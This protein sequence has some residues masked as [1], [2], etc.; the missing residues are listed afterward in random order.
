M[1]GRRP[2]RGVA[3][4]DLG[5]G[6]G[7]AAAFVRLLA[8]LGATVRAHDAR[9]A[10]GAVGGLAARADVIVT[11]LRAGEM[12]QLGVEL[13]GLGGPGRAVV[14]V[15]PFGLDG[16][17][18][19]RADVV[20]AGAGADPLVAAALA[21]AHA[22]VAALAALRWARRD[23]RAALVE[24]ATVEVVA[25]CLGD[26]LPRATCPRATA[27]GACG[28]ASGRGLAVLRCA[29]G[30]VG[31]MAPS[32]VDHDLLA[33]LMGVE[34][35][36]DPDEDLGEALGP[37]LAARG[38]EEV[39]HEAQAWRLPVAPVLAP[40][41]VYQDAQCGARGVWAR[42][43]GEWVAR[44]PF[45]FTP[46]VTVSNPESGPH[47]GPLPGGEGEGRAL[48][49]TLSQ[50]EREKEE[51]GSH[52]DP[53][54]G[55]EGER[56]PPPGHLAG[57]EGVRPLAGLRVLDLGMV[58]AGPWCGR[59]LA[60]LGARVVKVEGPARQ[61]GTRPV[62]VEGPA[63]RD[64]TRSQGE[65]GCAGAFADLNRGK[66]SL[67]L[68][69]GSAAGRAAFLRL[70]AGADI[71]LENFSP[72]VMPNFGLDYAALAQ[73]NPCLL[74]LSL[75]AFGAS[76]PWRDYVAYG[77]GLELA[78]GLAPL[79]DGQPQPAPVAYLDY[80][81]GAYGA[82]GLLAALLARDG[83]G[84]GGHVEVAQREVACQVLAA[85]TAA[86]RALG[87]WSLDAAALRADAHLVARG[88]FAAR[89]AGEASCHHYAR[90]P[91]RLHDAVAPDERPAL[92]LEAESTSPAGEAP[93]SSWGERS[94]PAFGADSRRVLRELA[95]LGP[96]EIEALVGAGVVV[97][98]D[99]GGGAAGGRRTAAG[100][101]RRLAAAEGGVK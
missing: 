31:L 73:V 85:A 47:P 80:L 98:E 94:A 64:G 81:S 91:W 55:G 46:A 54:P 93:H 43:G 38:R 26:L 70:A 12:R 5:R 99:A 92:G 40:G 28:A 35:V 87:P 67:A 78:T 52:P 83:A 42:R 17:D 77:G 59:L 56:R 65:E 41:E 39:F 101:G 32:A 100:D 75:P 76:G 4:L 44:S 37:W 95:G 22:A 34:A 86:G 74:M 9:G 82:A 48:T 57:G 14:S 88:L 58:W 79:V 69:L 60:G 27:G 68:D 24:V 66:E 13:A 1:S 25:S 30:Y 63:R 90:L 15:T 84:R 89:P 61:D 50:G 72:R 45:R 23:G 49:P 53:L 71:V 10:P 36:R 11:D 29:D 2:L 51:V 33:G 6:L 96:A 21:G 19:E 97:A 7:A 3:V 18:A 62:K 16:P 8:Q 20:A